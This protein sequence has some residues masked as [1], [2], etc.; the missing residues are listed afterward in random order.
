MAHSLISLVLLLLKRLASLYIV[1]WGP[2]CPIVDLLR[3][4]EAPLNLLLLLRSHVCGVST[5]TRILLHELVLNNLFLAIRD[6]STQLPFFLLL[7]S[8]VAHVHLALLASQIA[9][10]VVWSLALVLLS[11]CLQIC[12]NMQSWLRPYLLLL[13]QRYLIVELLKNVLGVVEYAWWFTVWV[14]WDFSVVA[15]R[16]YLGLWIG[17]SSK[18]V[19]EIIAIEHCLDWISS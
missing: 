19:I 3:L 4:P 15:G 16:I 18:L 11:Q 2:D 14:L 8:P 6:I 12:R 5:Q 13:V 10:S 1:V 17:K 9:S 7:S